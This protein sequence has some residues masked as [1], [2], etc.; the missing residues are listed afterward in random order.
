MPLD[1]TVNK[2]AKK[3]IIRTGGYEEQRCTVMLCVKAVGR[4]L[5]AYIALK[6]KTLPKI[7]I[8]GII[9]Q[10][11]ESEWTDQSLVADWIKRV[12]YKSPGAL[13]NLHSILVLGSFRGHTTDLDDV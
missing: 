10:T 8:K 5:P 12:W 13:L 2:S 4:K 6:R 7:N 9:V 1:T 3:N 11:Y